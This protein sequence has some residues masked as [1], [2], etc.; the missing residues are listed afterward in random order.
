MYKIT[1]GGTKIGD[2]D[3]SFSQNL[4]DETMDATRI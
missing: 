2:N 3:I 4:N 1:P